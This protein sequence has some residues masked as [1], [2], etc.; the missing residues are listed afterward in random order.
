MDKSYGQLEGSRV[1]IY[2]ALTSKA[3]LEKNALSESINDFV[4]EFQCIPWWLSLLQRDV[5][6]ESM[7]V[8]KQHCSLVIVKFC[9]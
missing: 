4:L 6:H 9:Q 5:V 3:C 2:H 7:E 8:A 1:P